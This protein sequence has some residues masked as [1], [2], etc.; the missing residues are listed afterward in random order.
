MA[1]P[2]ADHINDAFYHI[3]ATHHQLALFFCDYCFICCSIMC[4][5]G[6]CVLML[7]Y[8]R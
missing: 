7:Y 5:D 2:R 4:A 6:I 3:L 8:H 1:L